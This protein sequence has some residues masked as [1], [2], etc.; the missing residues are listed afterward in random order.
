MTSE[1][2][3]DAYFE[4]LEFTGDYDCDEQCDCM[5][6]PSPACIATVHLTIQGFIDMA[7]ESASDEL[8]QCETMEHI[9]HNLYFSSVGH[10]AGFFDYNLYKLQDIAKLFNL[11]FYVSD[12]NQLEC[13]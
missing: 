4:A 6:D 9:G 2:L 10:G 13:N 8:S 12:D 3:I 5:P 11:E 7:M 1:D